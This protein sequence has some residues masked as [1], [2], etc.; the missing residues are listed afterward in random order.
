M[1]LEA[2]NRLIASD[3]PA[4]VFSKMFRDSGFK[5]VR[6]SSRPDFVRL[7]LAPATHTHLEITVAVETKPKTKTLYF[8]F[9]EVEPHFTKQDFADG[10]AA[11]AATEI[12]KNMAK[13]MKFLQKYAKEQGMEF[14]HEE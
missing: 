13:V 2:K 7:Y 4:D 6:V 10:T 1:K 9:E 11:K 3:K 14:V 5:I 8:I 12:Q